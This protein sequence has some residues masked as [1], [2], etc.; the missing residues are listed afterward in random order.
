MPN[1]DKNKNK[2]AGGVTPTTPKLLERVRNAA[3]N[4]LTRSGGIKYKGKTELER[5]KSQQEDEEGNL[6]NMYKVVTG[7]NDGYVL[8]SADTRMGI[9]GADSDFNREIKVEEGDAL[10][11]YAKTGQITGGWGQVYDKAN[12]KRALELEDGTLIEG[13]DA[14]NQY[15]YEAEGDFSNIANMIEGNKKYPMRFGKAKGK[16]YL[17]DTLHGQGWNNAVREVYGK[18]VGLGGI[19]KHT[20][21]KSDKISGKFLRPG[22]PIHHADRE[23]LYG[24]DHGLAFWFHNADVDT[25]T[26]NNIID[27]FNT[28][29]KGIL[30]GGLIPRKKPEEKD[31]GRSGTSTI[32]GGVSANT[33]KI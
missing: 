16:D 21:L 23:A 4:F 12:T 27:R 14:I 17:A 19:G 3:S 1:G 9:K 7:E 6:K 10:T 20:R 15:L 28:G 32:N 26:V 29:A 31:R 22:E 30:E 18:S 2:N 13:F 11:E 8:R 24:S 33:K 5:L 25:M